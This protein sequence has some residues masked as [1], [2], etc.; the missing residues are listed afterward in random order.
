MSDAGRN[1]RWNQRLK[2][3]RRHVLIA[4]F[5]SFSSEKV[6]LHDVPTSLRYGICNCYWAAMSD[7][8]EEAY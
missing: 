7:G 4:C 5:F 3:S 8:L 2:F 6:H 1:V